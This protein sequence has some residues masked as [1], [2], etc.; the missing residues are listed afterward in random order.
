MGG[1]LKNKLFSIVPEEGRDGDRDREDDEEDKE[2]EDE[3]E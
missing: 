2:D 3:E 1:G